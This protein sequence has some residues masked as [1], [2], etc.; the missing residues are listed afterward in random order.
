[1]GRVHL[2]GKVH[3]FASFSKASIRVW[4]I[5]NSGFLAWRKGS[6]W[7]SLLV[8]SKSWKKIIVSWGSASSS[9]SQWKGKGKWPQVVPGKV[10][11]GSKNQILH[12]KSVQTLEWTPQGSGK[13]IMPRSEQKR[14]D[15]VLCDMVWLAGWSWRSCSTLMILF[16][17]SM[18]TG[19][20][21]LNFVSIG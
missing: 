15:V 17:D 1:M 10:Q 9:G 5:R 18:C 6:S 21:Q 7:E 4:Y 2:I 12:W 13:V 14:L 11:V 19:L 8:S 3:N 16:H 20:V